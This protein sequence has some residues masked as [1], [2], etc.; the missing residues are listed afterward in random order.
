VNGL[1][2]LGTDLMKTL[3]PTKVWFTRLV[4][5]ALPLPSA[6]LVQRSAS[7]GSICGT[8]VAVTSI[9]AQAA[10]LR[11]MST[12]FFSFSTSS[13]RSAIMAPLASQTQAATQCSCCLV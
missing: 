8:G 11:L 12:L 2:R 9:A 4:T 6:A 10:T 3:G 1:E 13:Q 7:V 5:Q